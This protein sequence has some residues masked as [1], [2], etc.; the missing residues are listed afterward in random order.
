MRSTFAGFNTAVRGVN[1]NQISLETVGHNVTNSGV[2]GYSRQSVNLSVANPETIYGAN[3]TYQLGTG[4]EVQSV[5]RAR[6]ELVNK[7][8]WK[9][10][11]T[12][13]YNQNKADLLGKVENAFAEPTDTGIQSVM[14]KF[15]NSLQTLSTSAS[16][17]AAR[18]SVREQGVALVNSIETSTK[19]LK[20]MIGD[21][22]NVIETRVTKINEL[23]SGIAAL[24]KQIFNIEKAGNDNANDLRDKR[25]SMV[26]QLSGIVD[27]HV[28][29]DSN[30]CFTVQTAGGFVLA[31]GGGS[32]PLATEQAKDPDYG[33]NVKY[34]KIAGSSPVQYVDFQ[35]GEMKS[36]MDLRD[37]TQ[38]GIKGYLNN[39]TDVSQFLLQDFNAVHLTGYGSDN[40][41]SNNFFGS[42][43]IYYGGLAAMPAGMTAYTAPALYAKQ[44]MLDQLQVNQA[45]FTA[46]GTAKI[47][48][49]T[50]ANNIAVSQSNAAGPLGTI[51]SSSGN[52]TQGDTPT[53][54]QFTITATGV[55]YKSSTDGGKTWTAA[56]AVAGAGPYTTTINGLTT[57]LSIAAAPAATA[58]DQYNFTLSKGNVASGDNAVLM[59]SRL[60]IDTN[61]ATLGY[62]TL[63]NY[64]SSM[65]GALGIQRDNAKNS[66]TN[67]QTMVD[68]IDTWRKSVSGVNLDEE[69]TNMLKFQQGYNASARVM[70]TIDSMLDKLINDT[71][72]VGR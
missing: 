26:D 33:Y 47:A 60:K 63:D 49:K 32:I 42:A 20:N 44:D 7:Q 67:Q 46:S 30:G 64:Y 62:K 27:V 65:I 58:G 41:T 22:N 17:D 29:Q 38:G 23:S 11:P 54:V 68:Q 31:D 19:Q 4:V 6:N 37:S 9:E 34:V 59:S 10:N 57:V 51:T 52:Y 8:Y 45:L 39:L 50:A 28:T 15:W 21:I 56:T 61:S 55:S 66:S 72:M 3:G 25:D 35:N 16:D 40:S 48:A 36:L 53:S 18:T 69:M 12:L 71:G 70:T 1:A 43:G 14:D 5:V 13:A 2:D 24:N